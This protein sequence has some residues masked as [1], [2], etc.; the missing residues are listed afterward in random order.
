MA[1]VKM[2]MIEQSPVKGEVTTDG[3]EQKPPKQVS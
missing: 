1:E 2:E 3:S